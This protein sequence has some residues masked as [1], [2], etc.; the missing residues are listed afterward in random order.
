[1][2]DFMNLSMSAMLLK[3]SLTPYSEVPSIS[4]INALDTQNCE[5][6]E[7]KATLAHHDIGHL[8]AHSGKAWK[9]AAG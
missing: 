5:V 1:M 7:V 4:T 8:S 6:R 9:V 3:A 2:S